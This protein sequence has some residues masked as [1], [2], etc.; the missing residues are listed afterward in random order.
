[1]PGA[2]SMSS[3]VKKG[4]DELGLKAFLVC[5]RQQ[6]LPPPSHSI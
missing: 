2:A 1:M 5:M 4:T 3:Y 6:V